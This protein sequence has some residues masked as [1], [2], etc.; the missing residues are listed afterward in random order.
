MS[1]SKIIQ[2]ILF[3]F[4]LLIF[5]YT[6]FSFFQKNSLSSL[7]KTKQP[8]KQ[9]VV[10]KIVKEENINV[11]KE[12]K[13]ASNIIKNLSYKNI[14]YKGNIF[15]INSEITKIFENE[16]DINYMEI[17]VTNIFLI[18]GRKIEIFSDKAIYDNNNY[19][20]KFIGNVSI[21]EN[22][23]QITANNLDFF[24]N[25]NLV[26][27]YNDVKYKGYNKFLVADR[28][29]INL[30]DQKANIYMND[31]INKVKVSFKN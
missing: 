26:T 8:D 20:A 7:N 15:T 1:K 27:I 13:E 12:E 4:G 3:S 14:D 19:N 28:I 6:Y 17:V 24:F 18:D 30:L 31:K 21:F 5:I 16:K 11:I 29:D 25:K 9:K 10:Q 2:I 22:E 23:N